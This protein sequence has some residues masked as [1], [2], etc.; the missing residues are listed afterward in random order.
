MNRKL[1]FFDLE[2]GGLD[3]QKHAIT[4]L[5]AVAVDAASFAELETFERKLR[6][7]PEAAEKEALDLGS[8]DPEA[9]ERE[10]VAPPDALRDFSAFLSDH[11]T[12]RMVSARTGKDYFVARLA[13][14]NAASFDMPFLRRY[15]ALCDLFLPG[16][17]L[18]LDTAQLAA[19]WNWANGGKLESVKL[20]TLAAHFGVDLNAHDALEDVRASV[21]VVKYILED[22]GF[23]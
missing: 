2:T 3:P 10:A 15:F 18:A 4:Q 13:G 23:L 9:W 8:Y 11:A 21:A 6:F 14:H 5:A 12:K 1:V 20:E 7:K 16:Y 22:L 17:F 19:W